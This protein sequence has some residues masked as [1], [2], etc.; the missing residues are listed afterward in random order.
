MDRFISLNS[1]I[2]YSEKLPELI[3]ISI[4]N[5]PTQKDIKEMIKNANINIERAEVI[6]SNLLALSCE[7]ENHFRIPHDDVLVTIG[8]AIKILNDI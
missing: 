7:T 5:D 1:S 3:M 6:L 4:P 8:T 2:E